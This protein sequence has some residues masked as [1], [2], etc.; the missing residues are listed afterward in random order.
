MEIKQIFLSFHTISHLFRMRKRALIC[1]LL[2]DLEEDLL[3]FIHI[4]APAKRKK[5]DNIF[6]QRRQEGA[7]SILIEKYLFSDQEKFISFLRVTPR[8]FY[9]I[10]KHVHKDIYVSPCNRVPNPIDPSQKLC[11]ALRYCTNIENE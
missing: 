9:I 4:F 10:L 11:I 6:L 5:I 3:E 1:L 2:D 8:V 7:F